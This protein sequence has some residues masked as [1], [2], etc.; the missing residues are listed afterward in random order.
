MVLIIG[1][2]CLVCEWWWCLDFSCECCYCYCSLLLLRLT[3][4]VWFRKLLKVGFLRSG[5]ALLLLSAFLGGIIF[6]VADC[7]LVACLPLP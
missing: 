4:Y 5:L 6:Y 7:P 1:L 3:F 2:L